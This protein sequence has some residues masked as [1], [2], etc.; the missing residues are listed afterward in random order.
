MSALGLIT[1]RRAAAA[2]PKCVSVARVSGR[3][4]ARVPAASARCGG[5]RGI[6]VMVSRCGEARQSR[7]PRHVLVFIFLFPRYSAALLSQRTRAL[8]CAVVYSHGAR[9]LSIATLN[10]SELLAVAY[11]DHDA[12]LK[13]LNRHFY[14]LHALD[15]VCSRFRPQLRFATFADPDTWNLAYS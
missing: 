8:A 4:A 14:W 6:A 13:R 7:H 11:R 1:R 12:P 15:Q 9:H 5:G 10:Q 3:C 2:T